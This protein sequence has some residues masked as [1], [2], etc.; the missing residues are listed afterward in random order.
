MLHIYFF[1]LD[2]SGCG[3]FMAKDSEL[4]EVIVLGISLLALTFNV[5]ID[6]LNI[7]SMIFEGDEHF[8]D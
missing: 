3:H 4:E 1:C 5:L 7:L 2:V 6:L 8:K